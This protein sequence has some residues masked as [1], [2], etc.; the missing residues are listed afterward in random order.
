MNTASTNP[1]QERAICHVSGPIEVLA[2][3]GSGKT[4]TIVRRILH[5]IEAERVPPEKILV[6]TFTK[7][8]ALE[9]QSR[10]L[11]EIRRSYSAVSF[12]TFHSI[13]YQIITRSGYL[14][15]YSLISEP[16]KKKILRS[17][18]NHYHPSRVFSQ[19]EYAEILSEISLRK[20]M[21]APR[22]A[23]DK[24]DNIYEEY[25][26]MLSDI[27]KIDFDDMILCCH[28]MLSAN[29][30]TLKTWQQYFSYVL[31][32]EFQDINRLQYMVL[33]QIV[34]PKNNLFI[35]GDDDQSIYGFRGAAPAM[36]QEF[37]S[38]FT[39]CEQVLLGTNYRSSRQIVAAASA[40]IAVNEQRF[41]KDYQ[42]MRDGPVPQL[43]SFAKREAEDEW[44]L[45]AVAK[46][47]PTARADMAIIMRT[48]H[49]RKM[50][51]AKCENRGIRVQ[52][53]EKAPDIFAH[54][55][56]QD[57]LDYILFSLGPKERSRFLNII[58]KPMRY[59][60][61]KCVA[62]LSG[63]VTLEA[64]LSYYRGGAQ[65]DNADAL[66]EIRRFFAACNRIASLSPH[67]AINYIRKG[68]GYDRYLKERGR[69]HEFNEWMGICDLVQESAQG[70]DSY[71]EWFDVIAGYN[72]LAD[73]GE[74]RQKADARAEN[75]AEGLHIITMHGAKGLEYKTV[76]LPH[77]N[78]GVLPGAKSLSDEQIEEERRLFYVGMTRA[79]E[80]LYLTY[81]Q[82][83]KLVPSRF[84]LPIK[85]LIVE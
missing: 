33:K 16:E 41:K 51:A 5:L 52:S 21:E 1:G 25:C 56:A 57:I 43:I 37:L 32:D 42:A 84:L 62:T 81:T 3:P 65:G 85:H 77:L 12:G 58:N 17:I 49:E 30:K 74:G 7:A 31:V 44:I 50:M 55:C 83:L 54:F 18:L 46:A 27:R 23:Y 72:K 68:I 75:K 24:F 66:A 61:R 79:K 73:A 76:F 82:S 80:E 53:A 36:M 6:I 35:V 11:K 9:M 60:S 13:Y 4:F 48:N 64:V 29:E 69:P 38:D 47:A 2:G 39:G 28:E 19:T 63:E 8:A 71:E 15:D 67:L 10:F 40:V 22:T 45:D 59:L 34:A 14:P 26:G 70:M 20:N 78:E